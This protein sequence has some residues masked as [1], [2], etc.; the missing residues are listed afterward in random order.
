MKH[1]KMSYGLI[2]KALIDNVIQPIGAP[3]QQA[4]FFF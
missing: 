2:W 4:L 1:F 3:D